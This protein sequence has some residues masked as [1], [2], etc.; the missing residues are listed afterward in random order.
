MPGIGTKTKNIFIINQYHS[1][2]YV[3]VDPR[4]LLRY[5]NSIKSLSCCVFISLSVLGVLCV[6]VVLNL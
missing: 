5:K 1:D 2:S 4:H 3:P 6:C